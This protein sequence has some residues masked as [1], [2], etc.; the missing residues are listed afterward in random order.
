MK[1]VITGDIVKSQDF[2]TE[3]WHNA[4]KEALEKEKEENWEIYR[5]DEFQVLVD[6]AAD[7]FLKLMQIKAKIKKIQDL[8]V[9]M[10]IGLGMQDFKGGKVSESNGSAFV[11][12]GRN[13]DKLKSEKINLGI[14]SANEDF[15]ET[16]NLVFSWLSL[17]TDNWS[18]VSAEIMDIFLQDSA[19]NQE[20]V[21]KK[22]N[23][24]QSSVSQR[25]KRAN[26]DLI[27]ET[28]KYFRKKVAA[29]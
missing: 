10:S 20:D 3:V 29:L 11:N 17:V 28:D 22:L 2:D 12:S 23:I 9:R 6:D 13:L 25:L 4:L 14:H 8:D 26:Y 27:T 19:L 15:D 21:A 5:G 18:I 1:A 24:T 16:M 7:A